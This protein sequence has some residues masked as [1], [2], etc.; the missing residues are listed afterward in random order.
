MADELVSRL[1]AQLER[2]EIH[3][4]Q[5]RR[6]QF[7]EERIIEGNDRDIFWDGQ[8]ARQAHAFQRHAEQIVADDDGRRPVRPLNQRAQGGV[9]HIQ[10]GHLHAVILPQRQIRQR[11]GGLIAA[12]SVGGK[13]IGVV[14]AQIGDAPMSPADEVF[15][16]LLPG[17][18]V[19]VV[20]IDRFV[21]IGVS[22]ANEHIQQVRL[23]QIIDDGI[24]LTGIEQN[25][26]VRRSGGNQQPNRRQNFVVVAA[27]DDGADVLMRV[28]ELIDAIYVQQRTDDTDA[29][30]AEA[31]AA[32]DALTDA[33]K[34]LVEGESKIISPGSLISNAL[35][36]A[37]F[38][39]SS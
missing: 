37:S 36:T 21:R 23:H 4:R 11:K 1:D 22:F 16:R 39:V 6:G 15:S 14:A 7:G 34:E 30:C 35:F 29:Q 24:A 5:S 19:V 26:R 38:K 10:R 12:L 17:Q 27:G 2:I 31:K 13:E 18:K 33:Q 8:P 28:A 25:K 32:W 3:R 20:D 9:L